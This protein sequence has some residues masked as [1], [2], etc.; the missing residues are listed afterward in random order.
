MLPLGWKL[1]HL[2]PITVLCNNLSSALVTCAGDAVS[3]ADCQDFIIQPETVTA[4]HAA[5]GDLFG[6]YS[7]TKIFQ[8]FFTSHLFPFS[9]FIA[10]TTRQKTT[11]G[12]NSKNSCTQLP[13]EH[14]GELYP[15][16]LD[17]YLSICMHQ[18]FLLFETDRMITRNPRI[19]KIAGGVAWWTN[20][21]II[22]LS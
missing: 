20:L 12:V 9:F 18:F 15:A 7:L 4:F 6:Q 2:H 14:R 21:H 17:T 8:R 3:V 13:G 16:N 10:K 1:N 11:R 22:R 5:S 19:M